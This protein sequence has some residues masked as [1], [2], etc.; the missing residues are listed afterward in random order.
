MKRL[1]V[2]RKGYLKLEKGRLT[3]VAEACSL[4]VLTEVEFVYVYI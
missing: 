1:G 2:V 4:M 3:E